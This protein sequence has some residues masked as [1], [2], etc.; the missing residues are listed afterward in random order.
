MTTEEVI[1]D[2]LKQYSEWF[3]MMDPAESMNFLVEQLARRVVS[4][5]EEAE[6]HKMALRR[7]EI[8]K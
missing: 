5:K 6:R 8:M 1:E 3:E 7:M 4:A 2:V